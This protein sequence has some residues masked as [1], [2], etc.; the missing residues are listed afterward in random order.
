MQTFLPYPNFVASAATLDDRRLNK[1]VVEAYQ[2]LTGKVPNR[3][4]PACLMWKG[5]ERDLWLYFCAC[6]EEY[7]L[8]TGKHHACESAPRK[9]MACIDSFHADYETPMPSWIGNKLFHISYRVNLLRKDP[10]HYDSLRQFIPSP[11]LSTYPTGYYWPVEPVGK[12]S[13]ADRAAWIAWAEKN[14]VEV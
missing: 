1:Q 14:G 5:H 9:W 2:I 10:V 11:D 8:R 7:T 3:N 4:H 12:K 6:C 13:K